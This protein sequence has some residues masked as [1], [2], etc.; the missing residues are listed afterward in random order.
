MLYCLLEDAYTDA[1][2]PMPLQS[3]QLTADLKIKTKIYGQIDS[4]TKNKKR[5]TRI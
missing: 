5:V 4:Y 1:N 3:M 2:K